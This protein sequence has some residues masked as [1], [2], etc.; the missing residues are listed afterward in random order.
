MTINPDPQQSGLLGFFQRMR[1]PNEQTGLTPFQQF[2]AAL[3][4]LIMPEMRAGQQIREQGAQRVAQGNKNK[5]I[6]FL[7]QKASEGDTVAAQILA[8]LE[9]NSLSVKDAMALY[10]N[11][12]FAK[13][14]ETF[15]TMTGAQVNEMTGS[16]LP[17][18]QLF[19]VS[20]TGKISKVGAGDT[21]IG[22]SEKAWEKGIGELGVK[23][24]TKIQD[25]A[26]SAVDMI[27]QSRVLKALMNDPDFKSG[28]LTEPVIAFKKVIEALGG[29]PA[30]V[31][32]QE[33]FQAVTAQL[34]LD[35]MG[36]S[37]GVGFSEGDRKFVERM[38]PALSTSELGNQLILKMNTAVAERKIEINNFANQ[39]I[40]QNGMIDQRF[41]SALMKWAK[42]NPMFVD[43]DPENYFPEG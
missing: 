32:S 19:N 25:D 27:G 36:G 23:T 33:A 7:Q 13:P 39:Y 40:E 29:D 38:A 9:N 35:K 43:I 8:G 42:A 24:L 22:G 17:E 34:I 28:A 3:D 37:L 15:K 12:V 4:P 20:T 1:K 30:N 11:Q 41:N 21:I 14:K 10:Y 31:G 16:S 6:Q 26:A 18:D 5:T 2:G